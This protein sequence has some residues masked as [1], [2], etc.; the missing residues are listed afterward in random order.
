[1]TSHKK[2]Q[3]C[4]LLIVDNFYNNPMETREFVLSQEFKVRGNY[5]G[6]RT[7]S[8]A[9]EHLKQNIQKYIEP[10]AGKI[11]QFPIPSPDGSDA[12]KIY[13][14]AFQYT[15]SRD[16]SWVHTDHFNDWAA[17][18]FLTPDAPVSGGTAFF[19]FEDGSTCEDDIRH[20][21]GSKPTDKFS[22]DMTK[23]TKIDEVGNVFNRMVIFNSKRFHMSMDYFGS[24]KYDGR[25]FQ[26][27]FFSTEK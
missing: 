12:D 22:Q 3:Y 17:V 11:T 27:F 6:Q 20:I 10:F 25:L 2:G 21:Q 8:Y 23:W 18:L 15:T 26:V 14:G 19:K 9:N 5:P 4:N 16:R 1:M 7:I 24:D 13:N